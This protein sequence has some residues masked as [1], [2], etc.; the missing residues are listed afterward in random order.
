[1]RNLKNTCHIALGTVP[2]TILVIANL[3][4]TLV[5]Y[6]TGIHNEIVGIINNLLTAKLAMT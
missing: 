6:L 3:F 2:I 4:L 1:M 5:A